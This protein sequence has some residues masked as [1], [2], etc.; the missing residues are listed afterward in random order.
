MRRICR[1]C[2]YFLEGASPTMGQ[3]THSALAQDKPSIPVRAED[4]ACAGQ[5]WGH[6]DY[7]EPRPGA[8]RKW[9]A[10]WSR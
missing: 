8:Q 1:T 9:W 5:F 4:L 10:F 6:K 7:W 3:C 2:K